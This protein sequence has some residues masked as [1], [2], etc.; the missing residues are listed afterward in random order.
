MLATGRARLAEAGLEMGTE[1]NQRT[2][3][4]S[5]SAGGRDARGAGRRWQRV[6][7]RDKRTRK[8]RSRVPEP[9]R[10]N[11]ESTRESLREPGAAAQSGGWV[12][13]RRRERKRGARKRGRGEGAVSATRSGQGGGAGFVKRPEMPPPCPPWPPGIGDEPPHMPWRLAVFPDRP[14]GCGRPAG[15]HTTR[16]ERRR[17]GGGREDEGARRRRRGR[18]AVAREKAGRKV[19]DAGGSERAREEGR[20][21][22]REGER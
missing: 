15:R 1:A 4:G 12:L 22:E 5:A 7:D 20:D 6:R 21:G 11:H 13:G 19:H 3:S 14:K 16:R 17:R 9:R 2:W 10:R 18:G 8:E